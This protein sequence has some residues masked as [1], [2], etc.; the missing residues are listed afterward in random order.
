MAIVMG[1]LFV[2]STLAALLMLNVEQKLLQPGLY[3]DVMVQQ[4]IYARVPELAAEQI[5]YS[6]TLVP[7]G[8]ENGDEAASDQALI[9]RIIALASPALSS[10]LQTELGPSAYADLGA[11]S[12]SPSAVEAE[13]VKACLRANG[14]PAELADTHGGMPIFFWML[15]EQD[16]QKTLETLLPPEWLQAQFESVIDQIYAD[17]RSDQDREAVKIPMADLKARLQGEDGFDAIVALL[18]AQPACTPDQLAQIQGLVDPS[19]PLKEVPVCRPPD[20]T[21]TAIYPNI[22]ATMA[23]LAEQIPDEAELKY[24]TDSGSP[25][26]DPLEESRRA[27][28][29]V[30]TVVGLSL[31]VPIVLLALVVAFGARSIK[32]L[33]RCLGI[34]L[35]VAGALGVL[36][37]VVGL[38]ST[39]QFVTNM[40][41]GAESSGSTMAPGIRGAG[42]DLLGAIV[43]GYLAA[44]LVQ[45]I[46]IAVVGLV[47]VAGSFL[48]DRPRPVPAPG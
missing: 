17:L 38:T 16:W 42:A 40:L 41:L 24:A 8:E 15:S 35:L 39:H 20:A 4:N 36:I 21:L 26:E 14:V 37:A 48:V 46:A 28:S 25:S 7:T 1:I 23:F 47:M 18:E 33:L 32:G 2:G 27:L 10:C 12:R 6:S 30:R 45:A 22:R 43:E 3:K 29:T 9:V 19:E 34:P 5:V 11:A 31:L 44:F 13:D